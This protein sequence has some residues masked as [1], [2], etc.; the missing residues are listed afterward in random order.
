MKEFY[1]KNIELSNF[2]K[3]DNSTYELNPRMNIFIGKNA[4]G[5]TA[6]L[7]AVT[8][9]LGAY[10]A[11]FKEYVPSRF[12]HNIS[13]NDV[14]RKSLKHIEKCSVNC[15]GETISMYCEQS[16]Y[17]GRKNK[18]MHKEV[19]KRKVEEQNL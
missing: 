1:L 9:I 15:N 4:S 5:K 8:V 7:E 12:G 19:W 3:F 16:D 13:D 2:R 17:V 6:V 18:E 11:A 14:L 10:L